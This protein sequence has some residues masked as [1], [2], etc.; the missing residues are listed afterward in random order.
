MRNDDGFTLLE[1]LT[2]LVVLGFLVL[3][4]NAGM[5]FG[6]LAW[7]AQARDLRVRDDLDP[8]DRT[9]RRLVEAMDPGTA[10]DPPVIQGTTHK[11]GFTTNMPVAAGSLIRRADVA[12]LVDASHRLVLRWTPHWHVTRFGPPAPPQETVLLDGVQQIDLSYRAAGP[13]AAGWVA[14]W[15]QK[16]PPALVRIHLIFVD[17]DQRHWPDIAA[18]MRTQQVS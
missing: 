5:H 4:L 16:L 2:A 10:T 12:L 13:G 11:L 7:H 18:P 1:M 14:A 8:V 15:S 3:A 6:T 9:L 17:G